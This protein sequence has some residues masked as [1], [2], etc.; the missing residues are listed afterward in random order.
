MRM[1]EIKGGGCR[2]RNEKAPA[3]PGLS[4]C[5]WSAPYCCGDWPVDGD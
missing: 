2:P 5:V 3:D 4:L 1:G